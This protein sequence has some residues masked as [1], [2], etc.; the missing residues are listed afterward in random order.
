[1]AIRRGPRS[2]SIAEARDDLARLVHEAEAGRAVRI[3]RRGRPVAALVSARDLDR[4]R[5]QAGGFWEA[6]AAFRRETDLAELRVDRVFGDVR[7]RSPGR[8]VRL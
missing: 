7:D 6:L 1:M 5:G 2:Y 8:R 4:L 3:T